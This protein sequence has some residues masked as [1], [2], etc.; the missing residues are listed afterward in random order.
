MKLSYRSV[1]SKDDPLS[2]ITSSYLSLY[3]VTVSLMF[4]LTPSTYSRLLL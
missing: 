2:R 1:I 3:R 4:F